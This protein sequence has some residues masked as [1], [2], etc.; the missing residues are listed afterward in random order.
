[1]TL[2]IVTAF[3][4]AGAVAHATIIVD[5]WYR[6]GEAD[7][8]VPAV[9]GQTSDTTT[10]DSSGNGYN[11]TWTPRT[12]SLTGTYTSA[13]A[14]SA[15]S[16]MG[17]SVAMNFGDN[18]VYGNS[19]APC[20][21]TTAMG[22]EGWFEVPNTNQQ[23]LAYDGDT[24]RNGFG[25]YLYGGVI[26]AL[27]GGSQAGSG[28]AA[29]STFVPT[30]NTWFYA[31]AVFNSGTTSIYINSTTPNVTTPGHLINGTTPTSLA[32]AGF[33][34]GAARDIQGTSSTV[35]YLLGAADEV[36]VFTWTGSN[37]NAATDLEYA[38]TPEPSTLALLTAGLLGL[39]A[40]AWRRRK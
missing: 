4:L 27:C 3:L 36:R 10:V 13:V 17:S 1:M 34:I 18:G 35:D 19:T 20:T 37:F 16:T 26:R 30:P 25:L 6:L 15:A 14:A 32:T 24:Y 7:A 38:Q 29:I 21:N 23:C 5:A 39:L 33:E 9:N 8:P 31:A 40:Y 2:L 28:W 22:V 11:L 12:G